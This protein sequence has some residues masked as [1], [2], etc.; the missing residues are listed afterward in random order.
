[1]R[2]LHIPLKEDGTEYG[3]DMLY[4]DQKEIVTIVFDTLHEF[5]TMD[6]LGDF[7]PLR[8]IINGQGGSGK[9]VVII[10]LLL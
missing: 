2:V 5:L 6:N 7:K 10:L 4:E 9:S 8:L 3:V 1:M